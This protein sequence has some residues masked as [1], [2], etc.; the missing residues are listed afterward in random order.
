[1]SDRSAS[2]ADCGTALDAIPVKEACPTCGGTRRNAHVQPASVV[3]GVRPGVLGIKVEYA[4]NRSWYG[5]WHSVREHLATV[6]A[7]SKPEAYKGNAPL[8]RDFE[9][10]FT[11]CFHMV[12]WL[13]NDPAT[14]LSVTQVRV[15]VDNDPALR[16]CAGIANTSKHHTRNQAGAMTARIRS[17]AAD[18]SSVQVEIGWSEGK[19]TGTEDALDLARRC[20]GAWDDYLKRRRLQSPI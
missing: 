11:N 15:F 14:N 1:M 13:G 2:C 8:Q 18:P 12:D 6:E 16:I 17:V 19:K 9:N 5:Q 7:H 20:V 3:V 4:P 10:F